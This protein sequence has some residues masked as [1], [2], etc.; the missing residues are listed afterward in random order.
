MDRNHGMPKKND[1]N[2][3]NECSSEFLPFANDKQELPAEIS[4]N[5]SMV[6]AKGSTGRN[7][8]SARQKLSRF[9]LRVRSRIK[10]MEQD[11]THIFFSLRCL[12]MHQPA[13]MTTQKYSL[14]LVVL[15]V[16]SL[17]GGY[18]AATQ[19]PDAGWR[20]F[21]WHPFLMTLGMV[22]LAGIGSVTKKLGGYTN[23]KVNI[24]CISKRLPQ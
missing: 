10:K 18:M 21:S 23:T 24:L 1:E 11:L 14:L 12:D 20:F 16:F 6:V 13:A 5:T 22:G 15:I 3:I 8:V 4:D 2:V 7:S 19:P 9:L 17:R